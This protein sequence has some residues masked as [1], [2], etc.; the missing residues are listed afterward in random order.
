MQ[1]IPEYVLDREVLK[2]YSSFE[3]TVIRTHKSLTVC[4][5]Y[6]RVERRQFTLNLT[7]EIE[8]QFECS[9]MHE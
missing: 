5:R 8:T 4:L 9:Q 2:L 3:F 1:S 7:N 6:T